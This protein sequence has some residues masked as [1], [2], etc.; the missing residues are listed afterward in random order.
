MKMFMILHLTSSDSTY[1]INQIYYYYLLGVDTITLHFTSSDSTC[2]T[3]QTTTTT[4]LVQIQSLLLLLTL[5][6]LI[7]TMQ[8]TGHTNFYL[9]NLNAR[10]RPELGE[11]GLQEGEKGRRREEGRKKNEENFHFILF[12]MFLFH[13]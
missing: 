3:N 1:T 2:T 11:D 13:F 9:S 10:H 12:F 8:P 4:Y 6:T 5:L 7:T